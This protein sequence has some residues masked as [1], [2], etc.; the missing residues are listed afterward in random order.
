MYYSNKTKTAIDPPERESK[1]KRK[2]D[3]FTHQTGQR[4]HY[5][6]SITRKAGQNCSKY[7]PL[8]SYLG[9]GM[10]GELWFGQFGHSLHM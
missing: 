10:C 8:L 5:T 7:I 6:K 1:R 9:V 2:R 4:K 3:S